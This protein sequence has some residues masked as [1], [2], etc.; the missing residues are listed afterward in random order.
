MNFLS[1]PFFLGLRQLRHPGLSFWNS[2]W[3]PWQIEVLT[4]A[5]HW[6]RFRI[7]RVHFSRW[8]DKTS[9]SVRGAEQASIISNIPKQVSIYVLWFSRMGWLRWKILSES[10]MSEGWL[11][12]EWPWYR[13]HWS[14]WKSW[15]LY[16]VNSGN[17]H[18][19]QW[20]PKTTKSYPAFTVWE[21][22]LLAKPLSLLSFESML[23][24]PIKD[25]WLVL[26]SPADKPFVFPDTT[27]PVLLCVPSQGSK[28]T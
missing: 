18:V 5:G 2:L 4:G 12:Y 20:V 1:V 13:E 28:T 16:P 11:I 17:D 23:R 9:K 3:K 22:L 14:R 24:V 8:S 21:I 10:E 19:M 15:Y 6:Q 26:I 25:T 7:S 27:L